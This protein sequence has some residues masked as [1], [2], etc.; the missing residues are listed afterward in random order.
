MC[1]NKPSGDWLGRL[2]L[3]AEL[4]PEYMEYNVL[5]YTLISVA[6]LITRSRVFKKEQITMYDALMNMQ[7]TSRIKPE[8]RTMLL[9]LFTI[10]SSCGS[11]TNECQFRDDIVQSIQDAESVEQVQM[12]VGRI[13]LILGVQ[14][15][16]RATNIT[17]IIGNIS[18]F[19]KAELLQLFY[20]LYRYQPLTWDDIDSLVYMLQSSKGI[21][22]LLKKYGNQHIIQKT[23]LDLFS[24]IH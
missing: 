14:Y 3:G 19:K 4:K 18:G 9:N 15:I 2:K 17:W 13:C 22:T 10:V 11:T 16:E 7:P 24:I 1:N 20:K 21:M 6:C 12:C 5:S 8:H 23:G